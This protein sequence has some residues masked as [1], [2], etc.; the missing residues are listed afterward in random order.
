VSTPKQY[1]SLNGGASLLQLS[2]QRALRLVPRER[3][4]VVVTEQHR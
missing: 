2:M 1:C 3:L 4:V